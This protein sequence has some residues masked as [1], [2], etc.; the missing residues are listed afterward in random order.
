[1]SAPSHVGGHR[2]LPIGGHDVTPTGGHDLRRR[3]LAEM[4]AAGKNGGT[5]LAPPR[6]GSARIGRA[7]S[8]IAFR[9]V[10]CARNGASRMAQPAPDGVVSG[11]EVGHRVASDRVSRNGASWMPHHPSTAASR[12]RL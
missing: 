9:P 8:D 1:M 7:N 5:S 6:P 4:A 2:D 11:A 10:G 3:L 12:T